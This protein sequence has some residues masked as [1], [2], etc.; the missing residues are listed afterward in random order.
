[1][2]NSFQISKISTGP[3]GERDGDFV[4]LFKKSFTLYV[5]S[6]MSKKIEA[7]ILRFLEDGLMATKDFK[8][9]FYEFITEHYLREFFVS[10]QVCTSHMI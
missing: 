1:M 2:E 5:E 10:I 3:G 4:K 6:G 8:A 9:V 7:A